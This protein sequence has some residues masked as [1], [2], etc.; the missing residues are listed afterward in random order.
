MTEKIN[1][2]LKTI[3]TEINENPNIMNDPNVIETLKKQIE[4]KDIEKMLMKH[5][6]T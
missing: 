4:Q 3:L 1:K 5:M 6:I 2:I